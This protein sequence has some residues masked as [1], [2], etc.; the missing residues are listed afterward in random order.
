MKKRK[1]KTNT[2]KGK[3]KKEYEFIRS[4]SP[5]SKNKLLLIHIKLSKIIIYYNKVH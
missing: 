4:K 3:K 1:K 5:I 2:K